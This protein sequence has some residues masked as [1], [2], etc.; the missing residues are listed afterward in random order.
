[1]EAEDIARFL[2]IVVVLYALLNIFFYLWEHGGGIPV[3]ETKK[4][5]KRK[6]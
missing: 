1:M 3:V 6:K 4:G 5:S 2:E